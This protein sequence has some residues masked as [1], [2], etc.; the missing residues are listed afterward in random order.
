MLALAAL[1][2][3]VRRL[4]QARFETDQP[5]PP[6]VSRVALLGARELRDEAQRA[7]H[8]ED[9]ARDGVRLVRAEEQRAEAQL[10]SDQLARGSR[11][12]V[13][14][15]SN[16]SRGRTTPPDAM[17]RAVHCEWDS[18]GDYQSRG[19]PTPRKIRKNLCQS[20]G[21][22]GNFSAGAPT[23]CFPRATAPRLLMRSWSPAA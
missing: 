17:V 19:R 1:L 13:G 8:V 23:S 16:P 11:T 21:R 10:S 5:R 3:F 22:A 14:H 9:A 7:A 15:G 6:F 4:D 20:F 2:G 18:L 12:G